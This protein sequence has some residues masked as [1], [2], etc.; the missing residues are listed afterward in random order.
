MVTRQFST[1][2]AYNPGHLL[3]TLISRLGL[4][5]DKQLSRRLKISIPVISSIRSKRMPVGA[6][7]LMWIQEA[8][9]IDIAELREL[10]GD[11]RARFRLGLIRQPA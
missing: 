6:S 11:R 7:L 2:N 4:C 10:M 1:R 9:G 3:D 8:T 5:S